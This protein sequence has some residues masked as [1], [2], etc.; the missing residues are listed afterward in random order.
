MLV[1]SA[2]VS[3]LLET[4]RTLFG[5]WWFWFFLGAVL[6]VGCLLFSGQKSFVIYNYFVAI[7]VIFVVIILF[8]INNNFSYKK[9][10]NFGA[11]FDIKNGLLSSLFACVYT[12]MNISEIRPVLDNFDKKSQKKFRIILSVFFSLILVFLVIIF[13]LMLLNNKNIATNSMPFLILFK[14][15]NNVICFIFMVGLLMTL[16]S[17]A[18]SCL[19]GVKKKINIDKNDENFVNIIVIITS[20]IIGQMP[21]VFFIKIIYPLIAIF[22]FLLFLNE[23]FKRLKIRKMKIF[24]I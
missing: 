19:I 13:S 20:L 9:L 11:N 10:L 14:S 7:F 22:N 12:F 21:F 16:I 6:V 23:I 17:T 4:S 2:M 1:A 24:K 5:K 3:G 8:L 15:Q 18:L